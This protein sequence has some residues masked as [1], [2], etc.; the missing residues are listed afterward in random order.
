MRFD[1]AD[2]EAA[3]LAA[4]RSIPGIGDW[5]AQYIA[6]RAFNEPDA[7]LSGDLILRRAAGGLSARDLERRSEAWRPWRAYAVMLLWLDAHAATRP[8]S[9][10]SSC[11][12]PA[13]ITTCVA[14]AIV[15]AAG[16]RLAWIEPLTAQEPA[17]TTRVVEIRSYNLKPGTRDRFH[18]LFLREALPMLRRWKVDV[19][20]YGPSLHDADSYFL[21]RGFPGVAERQTAKTRSTAATSGAR[22]RA[23]PCSPTSSATRPSW[24]VSTRPQSA[25][26]ARWCRRRHQGGNR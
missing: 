24:S 3:T 26:C 17:A 7:F 15:L 5:T 21:M 18:A 6:M 20:G 25:A 10:S 16:L 13:V 8:V 14:A 9:R 22:D 19:I 12:A 1:A 23:K 11:S 4:L 2:A